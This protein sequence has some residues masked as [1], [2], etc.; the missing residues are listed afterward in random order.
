MEN[1]ELKKRVKGILFGVVGV[2]Y[3]ECFDLDEIMFC[4][5]F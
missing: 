2:F 3:M 4:F 1:E 5:V